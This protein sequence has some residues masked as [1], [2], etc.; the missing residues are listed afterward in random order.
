MVAHWFTLGKLTAVSIDVAPRG[1]EW[2]L[3][4]TPVGPETPLEK[5]LQQ[6]YKTGRHP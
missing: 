6:R 1:A 2:G 5:S 3:N 4:W